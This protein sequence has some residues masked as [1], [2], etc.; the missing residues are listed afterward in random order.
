MENENVVDAPASF[1]GSSLT[2]SPQAS[3]YLNEARKWS[4]FLAILGFCFIGLAILAGLFAGTFIARMGGQQDMPF[5]PYIF[6][7]IY[8]GMGAIYFFPIYYLLKFSNHMKSALVNQNSRELD[9]AFEYLKSHYKYI[10]I[11]FIILLAFYV[12]FG[13][14]A[15]IVTSFMK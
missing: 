10:G 8:A 7:V 15:L 3:A 13:A 4:K 6:S 14:G 1:Q 9:T 11:L 2:V 12:F 5:P